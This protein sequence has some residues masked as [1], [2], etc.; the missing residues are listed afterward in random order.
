MSEP[1]PTS[2]LLQN[3][4]ESILAVY[5]EARA[6]E[7]FGR[8]HQVWFL[9]QALTRGLAASGPLRTRP[10][11]KVTFGVGQGSWAKVPWVALADAREGGSHEAGLHAALLFR[12]DMGGVY[13][14]LVEG[15]TKPRR[16]LG[17]ADALAFL[18]QRARSLRPR[19]QALDEAGFTVGAG[20]DL[21]SDAA[22]AAELEAGVVACKLYPREQVPDDAA[23]EA[24]LEVLLKAYGEWVADRP[25]ARA[26]SRRAWALAAEPRDLDLGGAVRQLERLSWPV[27]PA[28]APELRPGDRAYV[29]E[30][31]AD[32]GV[33]AIGTVVS[34][35]DEVPCPDKQRPFAR[36]PAPEARLRATVRIDRVLPE[37][38][39]AEA[40]RGDA[41]LVDLPDALAEASL[42]ALAPDTARA[43]AS[44][45]AGEGAASFGWGPALAGLVD[46]ITAR[47]FVFEPWQVAAY[48]SALR[49]KPFVILAG[50][51]GTGKSKLPALVGEATG[52]VTRLLS[53][54]PDW[55]DSSEVLGYVDLQG[56]FRPGALLELIREAKAQPSHHFVCVVDEMNLA[57]VEHYFA[58]VLS[59]IEDRRPARRGGFE[60]SPLLHHELPAAE[61]AW[62]ELGLP[63]NLALVGTVNMDES[64]HGFSRKVLD[65]AFTLEFS[66]VDLSSWEPDPAA[67]LGAQPWPV[68]TWYP[69]A[70]RPGALEA[71]SDAER[72][73]VDQ[74]VAALTEAN[75]M[76]TPAQLQVGYRTRD[77]I[78]LFLIHARDL[79]QWFVT[80]DGDRVDP[81]DLALQMKLLPRII[82]GSGPVRRAVLGL[83][84]WTHGGQPFRAEEEASAVM[85]E[86]E[87]QGRP[88]ALRAARYPRTAARL[89][90][91]WDRLLQEG[92]T[93]FWL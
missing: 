48:V 58:E 34:E 21:G 10:G 3:G 32:A 8:D 39:R 86:W 73:A 53:V 31:G 33:L 5:A 77:E 57:R 50:V 66:D 61:A 80:R 14:A 68:A 69:R 11:L 36:R 9:F 70:L 25:R 42:T 75:R 76:L 49:T 40:L 23:L 54:R 13:L 22:A 93:S 92:F 17:P 46:S 88:G 82:G 45:L 1:P 87:A 27:P 12:Q 19:F 74:V 37:R 15:G 35:P 26:R 59:R 71:P 81:M 7:P 6:H 41:R 85:A 90:L 72:E 65:R 51:S 38:L 83:L 47:G 60:S 89:A 28:Q 43:L 84:G 64:A 91:M 44:A 52:G 67:D 24:D 29:W 55:T 2:T 4:L 63:P 30:A 56:R 20:L 79:T 62:A 18:D 78:A 16:L